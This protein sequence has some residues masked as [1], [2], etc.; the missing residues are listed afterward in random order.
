[1]LC[2]LLLSLLRLQLLL[3]LL[4][5]LLLRTIL[6]RSGRI[7]TPFVKLPSMGIL[8]PAPRSVM[9]SLP[10]GK[11]DLIAVKVRPV[12]LAPPEVGVAPSVAVV[13]A[14][15][16]VVDEG[17]VVTMTVAVGGVVW[18]VVAAVST[19]GGVVAAVPIGVWVRFFLRQR[20]E[21]SGGGMWSGQR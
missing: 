5:L 17:I 1:M 14:V 21:K 2:L 8:P 18:G 6:T 11:L 12:A 9:I 10:L 16:V 3:L 19:V 15:A 7:Q 13:V 20:R 4:L